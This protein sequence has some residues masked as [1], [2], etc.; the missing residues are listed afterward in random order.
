[1]VLKLYWSNSRQS[2]V[3]TR[4]H[5]TETWCKQDPYLT[6]RASFKCLIYI[7]VR[8][9]VNWVRSASLT[10]QP[11]PMLTVVKRML[12]LNSSTKYSTLCHEIRVKVCFINKQLIKPSIG[13]INNN[14]LNVFGNCLREV[15][16]R[17]YFLSRYME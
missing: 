15:E 14:N 2:Y 17:R 6:S 16:I 1:M 7:Q 5:T 8:S 3:H 12:H 11:L 4:D 9:F 10:E 13:V